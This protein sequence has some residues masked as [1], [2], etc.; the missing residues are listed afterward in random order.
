ML[1]TYL[2]RFGLKD[3]RLGENDSSVARF[4]ERNVAMIRCRFMTVTGFVLILLVSSLGDAGPREPSTEEPPVAPEVPLTYSSS[5]R[6]QINY[7]IKDVGP[8]G[9]KEVQLHWTHDGKQW[10]FHSMQNKAG[11]GNFVFLATEEGKHG[12]RVVVV[13][14]AG[15]A[16]PL[17]KSGDA[18]LQWVEI[19]VTPPHLELYLPML[20]RGPDAG[21]LTLRWSAN[22]KNLAVRPISLYYSDKPGGPWQPIAENIANEGSY[23]WKY[24]K[25]APLRVYFRVKAVDRAGNVAS[26]EGPMLVLDTAE[27]RAIITGVAP[28]REKGP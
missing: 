28:M 18:P 9:V 8:S 10:T 1:P 16:A 19:D 4:A 12:F 23:I 11:A 7:E 14:G 17:P 22:D 25:D 20:G 5:K 24:P 6:I 13:S 21:S 27:P 15:I 2:V 3:R 26:C